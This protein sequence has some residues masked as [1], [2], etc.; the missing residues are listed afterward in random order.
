MEGF[1]YNERPVKD[2]PVRMS[3]VLINLVWAFDGCLNKYLTSSHFRMFC[4]NVVFPGIPTANNSDIVLI[5]ATEYFHLLYSVTQKL[6]CQMHM[7]E[8]LTE[9]LEVE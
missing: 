5:L 9:A 4:H 8:V 7:K 6:V 1:G 2:F 3:C